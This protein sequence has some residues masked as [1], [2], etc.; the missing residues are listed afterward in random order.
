[1]SATMKR[2]WLGGLESIIDKGP[3]LKTCVFADKIGLANS[4]FANRQGRK[5]KIVH[6]WQYFSIMG[7]MCGEGSRF[8]R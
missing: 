4:L 5:K 8:D 1:V 3:S 7:Q 6:D 2:L